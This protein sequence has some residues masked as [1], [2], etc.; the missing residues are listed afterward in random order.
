MWRSSLLVSV[1][2][3]IGACDLSTPLDIETPPFEPS[4]SMRAVLSAGEPPRVR[5]GVSRDPFGPVGDAQTSV[6]S[7]PTHLDARVT[8][9]RDGQPVEVLEA[10]SQTCYRSQRRTCNATTGEWEVEREEAFECG[11]FTGQERIRAGVTYTIR[12]EV[13]GAPDATATV[14]VPEPPQVSLHE[15][16]SPDADTRRLR[17]RLLDGANARYGLALFREYDA[18]D[19]TV[20]AVGGERDT[21]LEL[22]QPRR[23][24]SH[25][26]T[27]EAVLRAHTQE[28]VDFFQFVTFSDET[29][30]GQ[31]ASFVIETEVAGRTQ[32]RPTGRLTIQVSALSPLLFDAHQVTATAVEENPFAEPLSLPTNVEGGF[33]RVGA[34][35]VSEASVE[36][37][38]L[39]RP[40]R[41][42]AT[43]R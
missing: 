11:F 42:T 39:A 29:F 14:T 19:T 38:G 20:C 43:R 5:V 4:V 22:S 10:R 24:L 8:L 25:F 27:R 6:A 9:L 1:A 35:A 17:F 40:P 36:A 3:A 26:S 31:E 13:P 37:P 33:G 7:A 23:Y 21:T 18:Y 2:L 32:V 15:E 12:A 34:V 41:P 28:A 16:A 30:R